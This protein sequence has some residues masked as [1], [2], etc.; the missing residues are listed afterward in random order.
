MTKKKFKQLLVNLFARKYVIVLRNG[1]FDNM[2]TFHVWPWESVTDK[3]DEAI[4]AHRL[5]GNYTLIERL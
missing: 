3:L 1:S 5:S 4:K 2:A